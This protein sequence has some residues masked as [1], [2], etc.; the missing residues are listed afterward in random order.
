MV[1]WLQ[2][3]QNTVPC[4]VFLH[5][6]TLLSLLWLPVSHTTFKFSDWRDLNIV[7]K[8]FWFTA[9]HHP[10][11]EARTKE[12]Q[13]GSLHHASELQN[14]LP[15][16]LG[17]PRST[18]TLK[19]NLNTRLFSFFFFLLL[20][21]SYPLMVVLSCFAP[22]SVTVLLVFHSFSVFSPDGCF[23]F[24]PFSCFILLSLLFKH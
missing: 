8:L 6:S 21:C 12:V 11:D 10:L 20:N 15:E 2:L 7:P 24:D 17:G 14:Y 19:P 18:D 9:L 5:H 16:S 4:T 13:G 23:I 3:T 1:G 22:Q